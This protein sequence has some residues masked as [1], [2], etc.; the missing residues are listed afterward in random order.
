VAK[1]APKPA[2]APKAKPLSR[3]EKLRLAAKEQREAGKE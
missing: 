2:A 3:L 1:A